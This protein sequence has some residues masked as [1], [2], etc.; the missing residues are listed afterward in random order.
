MS[1]GPGTVSKILWHFT[2]GP[3]WNV[4]KNKQGTRL[5]PAKDSFIALKTILDSEVLRTGSF[6]E[7][8]KAVIPEKRVF[9]FKKKRFDIIK[10]FSTTIKSSPVCCIADIPIQ[11]LGYHSKRYGKMAIGFHRDSVVK[12]GFNPVLYTLEKSF[13]SRQIHDGYSTIENFDTSW[14]SSSIEQLES[15]IEKIF[16]EY[17][18]NESIDTS[19]A[20]SSINDLESDVSG[21][22]SYY[23]DLLAYIKTFDDS[24]FDS[25]YCEREWRSTNSFEFKIEDI[26]MIVLP[27]RVGV[28]K[29]YEPFLSSTSLPRSIPIVSW[30]DLIEH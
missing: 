12:A 24:E 16:D 7:V 20:M 6:H 18:L 19:D 1:N 28:N 5:K 8:V 15:A 29:Y 27:K 9:N 17:E 21:I 26:A 23:E 30:E 11:H 22:L 2:G 13:L 14:A 4:K 25:I 10:N 3:V